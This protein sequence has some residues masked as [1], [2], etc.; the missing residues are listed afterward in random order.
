MRNWCG[1]PI[2]LPGIGVSIVVL[3]DALRARKAPPVDPVLKM[4]QGGAL[5]SVPNPACWNAAPPK[6]ATNSMECPGEKVALVARS[7]PSTE[8]LPPATVTPPPVLHG[9]LDHPAGS[10]VPE[11]SEPTA[12]ARI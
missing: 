10:A 3:P 7:V 8:A 2:Q 4:A 9:V 5:R 1:A 12:G 11:N 6:V